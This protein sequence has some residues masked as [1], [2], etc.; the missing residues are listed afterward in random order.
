MD[1]EQH[2][3]TATI[4]AAT[5]PAQQN[6]L[7][8]RRRRGFLYRHGSKLVLL[9]TVAASAVFVYAFIAYSGLVAISS[10]QGYEAD[11]TV[12]DP[13]YGTFV[14]ILGEE[15]F[16][17]SLRNMVIFTVLFLALAVAGGLVLALAVREVGVGSAFFRNLFLFPYAL[18]FIVTGVVWRWLFNPESGLNAL[19]DLLGINKALA[20]MGVG[21]LRPGWLTDPE[22]LGAFNTIL[23]D[24][25]E[26]AGFIQTDLGVPLALV[27]IIIAASW[28]YVGFSMA[29]FLAALGNVPN[30]V[31]EAAHVD[32]ASWWQAQ[33]SIV[34]PLIR[35]AV[36]GVVIVL[37]FSALRI[38]DL[39]VAMS[40]TGPAFG[41]DVPALYVY[42]QMF[43]ALAY[44]KGA[45]AA[46]VMLLVVA[47]V[48]VPYLW[49]SLHRKEATE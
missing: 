25:F 40:G 39:V 17:A 41:T 28:Q 21:E 32:G 49:R 48:A 10:L 7:R 4:R 42:D 29:F 15:R 1:H 9:P 18:S 19:I 2:S 36:F 6:P 33:R 47:V 46:I 45:A 13:W 16:Q 30:E 38:F 12:T 8:K 27:P 22:V 35:S 23:T 26:W 14:E 20:A 43:R 31:R 11:L 3:G 37:M 34:L 5:G 24:R 44:N